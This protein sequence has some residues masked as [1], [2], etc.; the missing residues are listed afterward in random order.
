M[1]LR[2]GHPAAICKPDIGMGCIVLEFARHA[3]HAVYDVWKHIAVRL[4]GTS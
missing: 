3:C 1:K 2:R 4:L